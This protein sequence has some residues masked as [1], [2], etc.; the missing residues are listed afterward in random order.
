MVLI[1]IKRGW[2]ASMR[3]AH[4]FSNLF[5]VKH[6][7]NSRVGVC[8]C[9]IKCWWKKVSYSHIIADFPFGVR[10]KQLNKYKKNN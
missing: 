2:H 7:L 6:I 1:I 3:G 4:M 9:L 10:G 5:I 8:S